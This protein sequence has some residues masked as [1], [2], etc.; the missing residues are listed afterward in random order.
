MPASMLDQVTGRKP[1][2]HARRVGADRGGTTAIAQV[3]EKDAAAP[4]SLRRRDIVPGVAFGQR[5]H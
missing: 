3:I 4:V 1:F 2:T 5:T